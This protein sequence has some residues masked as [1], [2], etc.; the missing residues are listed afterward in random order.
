M[1]DIVKK[2]KILIEKHRWEDDF[3]SAI[4]A[5]QSYD[6]YDFPELQNWTSYQNYLNWID[7]LLQWVPE[8]A[9]DTRYVYENLVKFYFVLDQEPV[10]SHQTPIKPGEEEL[11]PLSEWIVEY[12]NE[13]GL[14]MDSPESADR[15]KSFKDDPVFHWDEY[16]PP[17]SNFKGDEDYRAYRTFN[18]F[19]AR[20]MKPGMCPIAGLC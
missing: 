5:A 6:L 17:P 18:Q 9:G 15:V 3:Y 7:S 12:A 16:M 19:F 11:T 2:L 4:R 20:H 13:W 1:N 10:K 8:Q 14:F